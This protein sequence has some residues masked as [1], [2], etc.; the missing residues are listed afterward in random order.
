M[1]AEEKSTIPEL[2][3]TFFRIGL[4]TFGGGYAMISII[5]DTCV[6]RKKWITSDEMLDMTVVAE[7]TPG[8][9]AINCATYVGYRRR[10]LAGAVAA[11]L[12]VVLPSFF[13]ILLIS[14][15][16]NRFLEIKWVA[17]AF[18]GIRLAV[19][20]IIADAGIKLIKKINMKPLAVVILVCAA[21]LMLVSEFLSLHI[22]TFVMLAGAA[23]VG[24][25]VAAVAGTGK[26]GKA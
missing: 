12:G 16:L 24:I 19:G 2:F 26:G 11:T 14:F 9:I 5:D 18:R 3:L 6:S 10:G 8:P 25:A 23:V 1:T 15:F 13:I 21:A 20:I 4:F 22:P 7:S 17:G